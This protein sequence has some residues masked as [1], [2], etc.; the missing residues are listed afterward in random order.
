MK[1]AT[2]ILASH[3]P[4]AGGG[5]STQPS[6]SLSPQSSLKL[7][8]RGLAVPEV[9]DDLCHKRFIRFSHSS[10]VKCGAT[11]IEAG[12]IGGGAVTCTS[13]MRGGTG[14]GMDGA[15]KGNR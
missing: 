3:W 14:T 8:R 6:A 5:V 12:G 9:V 15:F 2:G 4:P 13:S 7:K 11:A 10:F 1:L